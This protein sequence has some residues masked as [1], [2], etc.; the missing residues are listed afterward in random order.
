MLDDE[1]LQELPFPPEAQS[2][3]MRAAIAAAVA[4]KRLAD[5]RGVFQLTP[6]EWAE[7]ESA[8]QS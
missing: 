3:L 4:S 8:F 1:N 6:S 5:E 2:L 7:L